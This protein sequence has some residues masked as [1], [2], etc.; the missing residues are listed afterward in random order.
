[1]LAE[2][3]SAQAKF[4]P[5]ALTVAQRKPY[6]RAAAKAV[7]QVLMHDVNAM[8]G[9]EDEFKLPRHTLP[10]FM[11]W[12]KKQP[13][14]LNDVKSDADRK[15]AARRKQQQDELDKQKKWEEDRERAKWAAAAAIELQYKTKLNDMVLEAA[16][17]AVAGMSASPENPLTL[18]KSAKLV[19]CV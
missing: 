3:Q 7:V 15:F 12:K 14:Q 2:I 9:I 17:E 16:R 13:A 8:H 11:A 18:Q 5:D 1:M 10:A 4:H 6:E 19:R